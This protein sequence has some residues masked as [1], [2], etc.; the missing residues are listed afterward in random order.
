MLCQ[1]FEDEDDLDFAAGINE[2]KAKTKVGAEE[3][4]EEEEEHDDDDE[5]GGEEDGG[6]LGSDDDEEPAGLEGETSDGFQ[7]LSDSSDDDNDGGD[8]DAMS[9]AVAHDE[10]DEFDE[11]GFGGDS[12]N[13]EVQQPV[14]VVKVRPDVSKTQSSKGKK[15]KK[16]VKEDADLEMDFEEMEAATQKNKK[17]K[18]A[19]ALDP[20]LTC[21]NYINLHKVEGY[22]QLNHF[23]TVFRIRVFLSGSDS[24]FF[25]ESGSGQ[26]SDTKN[27][28]PDLDPWRRKKRKCK[29]K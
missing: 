9:G 7:S 11:E 29:Y 14:A 4:D 23:W 27:P 13:D 15:S 8:N 2:K 20:Y 19:K 17:K 6:D 18:F 5:D 28:D 12:D 21:C 16:G 24:P 1:D 26:Y 22:V 3:E 10:E 25:L